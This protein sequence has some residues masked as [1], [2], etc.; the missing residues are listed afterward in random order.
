MVLSVLIVLNY[1][2]LPFKIS[3]TLMLMSTFF[4]DSVAKD[5]KLLHCQGM[6]NDQL[7]QVTHALVISR[8]RYALFVWCGFL[9]IDL[10]N[11][12]EGLLKRLKRN[13]YLKEHLY[14]SEL[15]IDVCRELVLNMQR[16]HHSLIH[17]L[18]AYRPLDAL[19]PHGQNFILPK[20][21]NYLH[22]RLF[23][24]SCL[25]NLSDC[26][27]VFTLFSFFFI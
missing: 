9:T 13:G 20:C 16:S 21:H 14:F 5:L 23:I 1:L 22:K 2:V 24:I 12:L 18:P 17:L 6:S 4:L 26:H 15:C 27:F 7:D 8:L 3:L 25:L 11:R 10:M 19:R